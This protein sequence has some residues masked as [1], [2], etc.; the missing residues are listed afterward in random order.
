M[1]HDHL[2]TAGLQNL[3]EMVG[4]HLDATRHRRSHRKSRLGCQGCKQRKI[5]CDESR[6]V[7]INCTRREI[8]CSFSIRP[9][10]ADPEP[11]TPD[12]NTPAAIPYPA[13]QEL[14][15][16]LRHSV[17]SQASA[18]Q[19]ISDRLASLESS[20][21]RLA[22]GN[23]SS[24]L[25]YTDF[26]LFHF[27]STVVVAHMSV[28]GTV[29]Q[30]WSESLP[31]LAFQ[32]PHILHLMLAFAA[33]RKASMLP[34]AKVEILTEAN[35]HYII[36]LPDATRL[37]RDITSDTH[38]LATTAGA[39]IGLY[40]LGLGPQPG[41]Y[42]AFSDRPD[43]RAG[44]IILIRG[45]RSLHNHESAPA[46]PPSSAPT[47]SSDNTQ[48]AS[49]FRLTDFGDHRAHF[50]RLRGLARQETENGIKDAYL[51]TLED[52]E[53]FFMETDADG[54]AR[55]PLGWLYRAPERFLYCVEKKRPIAL[56]IVSCFAVVLKEGGTK[57]PLIGWAEHVMT[58]VWKNLSRTDRELVHWA[59]RRIGWFP[60]TP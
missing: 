56:A 21:G 54:L 16:E 37:L 34:D 10:A 3:F 9:S 40:H 51:E 26:H 44:F 50:R 2:A 30:F 4:P 11:T 23:C 52:L 60:D 45:I 43:G 48:S 57:W 41:E 8:D 33:T 19:T 29:D 58:G 14:L 5:K 7:C 39:L 53:V 42:L 36:G 35:R 17:T 47:P 20:V 12:G 46:H 6:P 24:S 25:A 1:E 13:Y 27:Y 22:P 15:A 38:L 49:T 28:D 55:Y 59:A 31:N 32:H 18:L